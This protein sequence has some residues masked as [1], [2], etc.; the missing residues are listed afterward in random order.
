MTNDYL[1][2]IGISKRV[3]DVFVKKKTQ[4]FTGEPKK[5]GSPRF[6][7]A[8]FPVRVI[9]RDLIASESFDHS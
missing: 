4:D 9:Y 2:K 5:V 3:F 6:K 8:Y 1:E 7:T